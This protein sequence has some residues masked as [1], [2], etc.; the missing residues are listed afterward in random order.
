MSIRNGRARQETAAAAPVASKSADRPKLKKKKKPRSCR[1]SLAEIDAGTHC[2]TDAADRQNDNQT[3]PADDLRTKRDRLLRPGRK[4]VSAKP[5]DATH[6]IRAVQ[7]LANALK[8]KDNGFNQTLWLSGIRLITNNGDQAA[9]LCQMI[10]WYGKGTNKRP[11]LRVKKH[12]KFW[13]AKSYSEF[14]DDVGLTER[15]AR[16]ALDG[17]VKAGL[18]KRRSFKFGGRKVCHWRVDPEALEQALA[19]AMEYPTE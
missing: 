15:Q 17:L 3:L 6:D 4:D 10:Y 13:V 2:D 1:K 8:D 7:E 11:R 18:L 9:C 5:V 19:R 12:G 16:S 14:G